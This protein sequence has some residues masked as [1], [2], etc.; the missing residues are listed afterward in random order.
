L[1]NDHAAFLLGDKTL[2]ENE[3]V[4]GTLLS[5]VVYFEMGVAY[6]GLLQLNR[7]VLVLLNLKLGHHLASYLGI[8]G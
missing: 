8:S 2:L 1:A 5:F 7:D 6:T 3:F 4:V